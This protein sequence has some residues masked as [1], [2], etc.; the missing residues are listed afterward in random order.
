MVLTFIRKGC[1]AWMPTMGDWGELKKIRGVP[2]AED[3]L[4]IFI[5]R[6]RYETRTKNESSMTD[7][8]PRSIGI[9]FSS[10]LM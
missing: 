6:G 3:I 8:I 2:L 5:F 10:S 7:D 4:Q 9:F 1:E